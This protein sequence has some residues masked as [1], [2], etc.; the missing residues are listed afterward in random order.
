M[1]NSLD[2][3]IYTAPNVD[4]Q[5]DER[6]LLDQ[7]HT[8]L[9]STDVT[10][11]EEIDRALGIPDLVNQVSHQCV[12]VAYSSSLNCIKYTPFLSICRVLSLW[13]MCIKQFV[14]YCSECSP[15]YV[16]GPARISIFAVLGRWQNQEVS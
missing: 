12:Q 10:S 7:L 14:T 4:G 15:G 11:L 8:L 3:L 5:S 16:L 9:S 1:R 13:R 2:D 6:A